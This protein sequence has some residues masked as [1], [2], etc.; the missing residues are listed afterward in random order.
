MGRAGEDAAARHLEERGYVILE[1]NH[2]GR[3]GEIDIVALDGAVL[4]FVEVKARSS[5][6]Y[7]SGLEAVV[8]RKRDRLR[9]A[10]RAYLARWGRRPP[11]CRFD[12]VEVSLDR[13]GR[14]ETVVVVR[15]AFC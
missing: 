2:R 12:V 11:T 8:R 10:A 3:A 5:R 6:A 14:P 13:D 15:N 4:C 9:R 7:G 1:R